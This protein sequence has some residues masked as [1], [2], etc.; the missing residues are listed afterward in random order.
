MSVLVD[1]QHF[2]VV[3]LVL[4]VL[5]IDNLKKKLTQKFEKYMM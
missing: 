3:L 1:S 2:V 4:S 5:K